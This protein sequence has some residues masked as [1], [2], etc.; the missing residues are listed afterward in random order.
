MSTNETKFLW[1]KLRMWMFL[2]EQTNENKNE[3]KNRKVNT[4]KYKN[5]NMN[6]YK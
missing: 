4:Q 6:K 3:T 2:N 5:S 1:V